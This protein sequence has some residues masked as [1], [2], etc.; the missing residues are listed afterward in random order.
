[1]MSNGD[2]NELLDEIVIL[3]S[4]ALSLAG[5]ADSKIESA[6]NIYAEEFEKGDDDAVYDYKSVCEVILGLK[7][8]HPHLFSE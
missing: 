3:L 2:Y 6:L 4:A 1:M 7:K 5:V 8:T